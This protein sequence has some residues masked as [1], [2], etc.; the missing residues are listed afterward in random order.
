GFD[1]QICGGGRYDRLLRAVGSTRNIGACGFAFGVERL[2][3]LMPESDIHVPDVAK[4]LVIP[5]DAQELPYAFHVARLFRKA[6]FQA[7][8]DITE[9]RLSAGLK[10][11]DKKQ[12]T[13]AVIVGETEREREIVKVRN[14]ASGEEQVVAIEEIRN[15]K[16]TGRLR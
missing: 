9:H 12:V 8:V 7:E 3:S 16:R 11:A 6:G 4:A 15:M 5:V 14:L 2:L 1:T 10:L 13:M